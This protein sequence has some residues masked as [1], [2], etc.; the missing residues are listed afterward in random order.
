MSNEQI[1]KKISEEFDKVHMEHVKMMGF[2]E[3][4]NTQHDSM[5]D[6]L[7]TVEQEHARMNNDLNEIKGLLK[8]LLKEK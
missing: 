7:R 5:L 3:S 8:S 6:A 4:V 1:L 2:F